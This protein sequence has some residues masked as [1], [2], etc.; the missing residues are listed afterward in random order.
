[1][2]EMKEDIEMKV[3]YERSNASLPPLSF[4][5]VDKQVREFQTKNPYNFTPMHPN[6]DKDYHPCIMPAY[7]LTSPKDAEGMQKLADLHRAAVSL[8][9]GFSFAAAAQE[10]VEKTNSKYP[11]TDASIFIVLCGATLLFVATLMQFMYISMGITSRGGNKYFNAYNSKLGMS[12]GSFHF[13]TYLLA[14]VMPLW[15][16]RKYESVIP[17][18]LV[19]I[20]SLISVY[21][22]YFV[23][24]PQHIQLIQMLQHAE[25][26][27]EMDFKTLENMSTFSPSKYMER[28]CI[29][30]KKSTKFPLKL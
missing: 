11:I 14:S 23:L 20:M 21:Y 13:A 12:C 9:G 8:L 2:N 7:P 24:L 4:D 1:M 29:N 22:D 25:L 16:Y 6:S 3:D 26:G 18:I 27:Y 17:M 15:A 28:R 10:A 5:V 19:L 30:T